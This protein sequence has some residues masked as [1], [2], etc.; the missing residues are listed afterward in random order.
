MHKRII[1]LVYTTLLWDV[2]VST[3]MR[4]QLSYRVSEVVAMKDKAL[5]R[6]SRADLLELLIDRTRENDQMKARIAELEEQLLSANQ[7]L[8]QRRIAIDN[9]GSIAEAALQVNGMIDAAQRTASQYIENIERIQKEQIQTSLRLEKESRE[10]A[11][12][13]IADTERKCAAMESEARARCDEMVKAAERE[14]GR[15]W[16]ELNTR[17]A[18]ISQE[19]ESMRALLTEKK[20][21]KWL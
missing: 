15:N 9:A 11:D 2:G 5:R 10:R 17:L 4:A 14:A 20:K 21:R 16:D 6:L 18:Q 3:S 12:R 13:L 1:A 8:E 7:K 19:N